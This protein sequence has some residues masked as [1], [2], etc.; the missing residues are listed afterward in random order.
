MIKKYSVALSQQLQKKMGVESING[1][2]S[3][4]QR[5]IPHIVSWIND[6]HCGRRNS[7]PFLGESDL[8]IWRKETREVRALLFA[9]RGLLIAPVRLSIYIQ[10]EEDNRSLVTGFTVKVSVFGRNDRKLLSFCV[11]HDAYLYS[12]CA[13]CE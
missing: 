9:N 5:I 8:E 1:N 11:S 12:S 3:G 13:L 6:F 7:W 10:S 2:V 4:V